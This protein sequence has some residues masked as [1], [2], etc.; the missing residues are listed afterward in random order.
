MPALV[1]SVGLFRPQPATSYCYPDHIDADS[2]AALP[3]KPGVYVFED[4]RKCPLYIGKSVNIRSRVRAHLRT[5][6]EARLLHHTRAISYFR[7]AGEI[8]ALL[9]ESR[10]IKERQPVHNKK[11]RR[12]REMCSF[13][14]VQDAPQLVHARELDFAATN[15]L[16]GLFA[17]RRAAL[18]RLQT[19]I[20]ANKLCRVLCGL[21]R[22]MPGKPC[23][24]C[25]LG[26]CAGA[27]VGRESRAEHG[28]RLRTALE[29]VQVVTW[30][31]AGPVGLIEE[32]DGWRQMHVVNRWCYLGTLDEPF[33]PAQLAGAPALE[34]AAF[35]VDTYAILLKP[36]LAGEMTVRPL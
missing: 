2:L 22:A 20:D 24:A 12:T 29:N 8:G 36:L 16:Y 32:C 35:D 34:R 9:L 5:P 17:T 23:F 11:L 27:C 19:L 10:L 28:A 33:D 3:S 4:E 14:L 18:E 30:P 7:T 26:R 6:E 25:Q 31:Y 13:R 1:T 21:E 15:G